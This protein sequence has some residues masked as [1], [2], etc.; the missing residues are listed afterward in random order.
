MTLNLWT[1][2]TLR[3]FRAATVKFADVIENS[4]EPH[5][6]RV[7]T[8]SFVI[9]LDDTQDDANHIHSVWRD[10]SGDFGKDLLQHH[11]QVSH[12]KK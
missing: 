2:S 10:F 3:S 11:Y 7:Q 12:Q 6:Y 8:P 5:Y 9:A 1:K 4:N